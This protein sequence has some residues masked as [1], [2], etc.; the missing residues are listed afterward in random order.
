MN[1]SNGRECTVCGEYKP[2][3]AFYRYKRGVGGRTPCCRACWL[4][5]VHAKLKVP[6]HNKAMQQYQREYQKR[7]GVKERMLAANN[8]SQTKRRL[9]PAIRLNQSVSMAIHRALRGE[10]G[11]R[12]WEDSVG[13]TLG[14]LQHH[15]EFFFEPGMAW[16]NYGQWH[17]DHIRP[18]A[19][20]ECTASNTKSFRA[21]WALA[22]LMP[23]WKT[24]AIARSHGSAQVGNIEKRDKSL[25]ELQPVLPLD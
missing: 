16:D 22:N 21:C 5:R 20:F 13:Y 8:R 4:S 3:A 6:K 18:K 14:Q 17:V 19:D 24:T 9:D 7:P 23:R 10:R 2:W 11:C 15:L 12:H 25:R 1:D